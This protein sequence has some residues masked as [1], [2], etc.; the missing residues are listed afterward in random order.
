MYSK[1]EDVIRIQ[2]DHREMIKFSSEV[3]RYYLQVLNRLKTVLED[4]RF[5]D[6]K[7]QADVE[8]TK[9]KDNQGLRTAEPLL[10]SKD[11]ILS[12]RFEF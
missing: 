5:V 8:L 1:D 6:L 12:T 11:E 2:A 4:C 7:N 3:D 9:Y 10:R